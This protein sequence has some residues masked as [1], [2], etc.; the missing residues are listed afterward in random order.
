MALLTPSKNHRSVPLIGFL[1]SLL[2]VVYQSLYRAVPSNGD[3]LTGLPIG[4]EL[5]HPGTYSPYDLIVSSGIHA[6]FYL[7]K[8]LGGF[9]YSLNAN[10]DVVWQCFFL[11]FL[12]LTF[13][14][15]W[16]LALELTNDLLSSALVLAFIAVAH[17]LRGSLHAAAVPLA[18][19]VTALS[20]MPFALAA[21]ILLLRRQF[22]ASML[23][24]GFVFDLHPYVGVLTG[25]AVATGIFFRSEKSLGV[26]VGMIGCGALLGLPNAVYILAH[27]TSNFSNVG[28]DFYSQ[29]RL[30]ALHVFVEDYWRDGYGWFFINLAGAVWFARYVD[31]WK[32]QTVWTLF[33]CWFVLMAIYVFN[34]YVT[35]NTAILLMFLL[36]ATYFIKP[37]IF[38]VVVHGIRRWRSE[39][40]EGS[41]SQSWWS[42]WEMSAAVCLLFFSSIL[43]MKFAVAA[44]AM[45]LLAYGLMIRLSPLR[46][47]RPRYVIASMVPVALLLLLAFAFVQFPIFSA[48]AELTED[49]IVGAVVLYALFLFVV[50]YNDPGITVVPR[51]AMVE[52]QRATTIAFSVLTVFIIHN[53]IIS[54]NDR[55]APFIPDFEGI[56]RR[57]FIHHAPPASAAL[58]Q[59]ARTATPQQSLFA[60]CPD[61]WDDFGGFRLAAERG[62]YITLVEVN[63]LSLDAAIYNQG[64]HRILA[65][66]T[67]FPQRG[68]YDTRGY[69]E[70]NPA[71]LRRLGETEHI[72]FMIFR[73]SLLHQ[74]V[75]ALP[76]AYSDE[77]FIVVNLHAP[78]MQ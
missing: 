47:T 4:K 67:K 2:C 17:P 70:L 40:Q 75:S 23:L 76:V 29:L 22:F 41:S 42:P 57:I 28:Y 31:G 12:F 7:Y 64:H 63:Q 52:G 24:S 19:F 34:S 66:G 9:L 35:K 58:V 72:D 68:E 20:A 56:T 36:R 44:D 74:N 18:S 61:D 55:Q 65:L 69:Y 37:I 33:A 10:V 3:L 50:F 71:D 8:Y 45:A 49:L 59:W 1:C 77:R 46:T 39:L 5:A 51:E 38:V 48:H 15:L 11:F 53:L 54:I 13:V 78:T 25:L 26:R 60:I 62:L 21:I 30:Y 73:K 16:Y 6:P 43:P 14:A 32:R 27:L